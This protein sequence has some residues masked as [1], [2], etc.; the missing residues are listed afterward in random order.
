MLK[1]P[2]GMVKLKLLS[3]LSNGLCPTCI[4]KKLQNKTAILM[5]K[6]NLVI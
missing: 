6:T 4:F 3:Q 1:I 2:V 5:I